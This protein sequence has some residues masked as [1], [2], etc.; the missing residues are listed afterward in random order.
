MHQQFLVPELLK[1]IWL[2]SEKLKSQE[3]DI[4][5]A[6]PFTEGLLFLRV[7]HLKL[8]ITSLR[9]TIVGNAHENWALIR[10]LS[11]FNWYQ[12]FTKITGVATAIGLKQIV[13]LVMSPKHND[14]A[15]AYLES[16]I[17]DHSIFFN[18][19]LPKHQYYLE[20]YP[21][22]IRFF[23]PLVGVWKEKFE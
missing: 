11:F 14:S 16:K 23:G 6:C 4:L 17:S 8:H 2:K 7:T 15:I 5:R 13:E 21:T 22:L 3:L 1:S 12:N 19:L 9:K 18:R 10:M 20:H